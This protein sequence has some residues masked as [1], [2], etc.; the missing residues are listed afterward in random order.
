MNVTQR[1]QLLILPQLIRL[2]RLRQRFLLFLLGR[3]HQQQQQQQ[4]PKSEEM[5]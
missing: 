2:A 4:H 3:Q 1:R 5:L